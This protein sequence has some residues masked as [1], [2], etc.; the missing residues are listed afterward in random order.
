M[1][2]ILITGNGFD[3]NF[4]L[5][6]SY[7]DLMA[8]LSFIEKNIIFNFESIYS[9]SANFN[10]IE[11]YFD[12]KINFDIDG[13]N[14]LKDDLKQN[15]WF[16]FFKNELSI[17]TW[18]NFENKINYVINSLLSSIS[19]INEKFFSQKP[20]GLNLQFYKPSTLNNNIE[21]INI[22][23]FFKII[24]KSADNYNW[25]FNKEYLIKK[26]NYFISL[27][28]QK[29]VNFLNQQLIEFKNIFNNYFS[30]FII[31]LYDNNEIKF[32]K[33]ILRAINYYFTFNYTPTFEKFFPSNIKSNY[34]HGRINSAKNSIVLGI[35]D[36][37]NNIDNK[38]YFL[39][40]TKYYQKLNNST[41][42]FFLDEIKDLNKNSSTTNYEFYFWGHSL[43]RSD[44]DYINEIFDFTKINSNMKKIIV[45]Y[46]DDVSRSKLLLNLLD[47]RGKRD[48]LSKMRKK[49]LIF[50]KANSI[51]LI[52]ALNKD[53]HVK[54]YSTPTIH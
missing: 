22:L 38:I 15:L 50:H 1:P 37:P 17:E 21:I 14:S 5:P 31:P 4:N 53:I 29:I 9:N 7:S 46:H 32:D 28:T 36:V 43:D 25:T 34:L 13:I 24:L 12:N 42:Y 23:S 51:E 11:K 45:I 2:K 26:Y 3:L 44:E 33:K 10:N 16:Q 54:I 20:V 52:D 49:E 35:N 19:I 6:T 30:L 8:V 39:P 18:I 40:F 47:I 48:I 27:D 41:D